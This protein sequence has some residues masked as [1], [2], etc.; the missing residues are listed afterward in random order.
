LRGLHG[1]IGALLHLLF[2][3]IINAID[4][5]L[6]MVAGADFADGLAGIGAVWILPCHI[7]P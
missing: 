1:G 4:S 6:G 5:Y 3:G 7:N 2:S